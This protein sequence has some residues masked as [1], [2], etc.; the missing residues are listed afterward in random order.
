MSKYTDK[1][2]LI[3][4]GGTI[5][6]VHDPVTEK[7]VFNDDHSPMDE[8]LTESMAENVAVHKIMAKD[9]L[10]ITDQDRQ[11][12]ADTIK[13]NDDVDSVVVVHG[14]STMAQTGVFLRKAGLGQNQTIILTG[15]FRP[16]SLRESDAKFN[17][18]AA[19]MAS[20]LAGHGV[21][22]CM[23]GQ[24]FDPAAVE[25]DRPNSRFKDITQHA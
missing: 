20:R 15:A 23:H 8:A 12:I 10:D 17:I 18:G 21:Y 22:L 2:L 16:F 7:L 24:L 25:K 1:V 9:S 4:T 3:L 5:E 11:I 19:L 14:T 6:K 13:D